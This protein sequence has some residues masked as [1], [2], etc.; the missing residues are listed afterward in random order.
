MAG[1]LIATLVGLFVAIP[2]LF[3][4]NSLVGWGRWLSKELQQFKAE[5]LL[6][7]KYHFESPDDLPSSSRPAPVDA[8]AP[9]KAGKEP[10]LISLPTGAAA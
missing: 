5:H 6:V 2:A 9:L 8:Q 1:A 4:Y 10:V 7:L 3:A